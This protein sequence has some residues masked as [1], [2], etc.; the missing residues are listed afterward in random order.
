MGLLREEVE[1]HFRDNDQ[2]VHWEKVNRKE[3]PRKV[4]IQ[5]LI[6]EMLEAHA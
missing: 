2:R 5:E 4:K 1:L 6:H 3:P